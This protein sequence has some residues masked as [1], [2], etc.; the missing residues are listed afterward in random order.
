MA[1]IITRIRKESLL[2]QSLDAVIRLL[3]T[4]HGRKMS[5]VI[6]WRDALGNPVAVPYFWPDSQRDFNC[7]AD[8]ASW[9][10]L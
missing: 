6:V 5:D 8:P 2:V 10:A 1:E 3:E 4:L 7:I 9:E